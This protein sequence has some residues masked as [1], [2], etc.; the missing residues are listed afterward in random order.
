[1]LK[2]NDVSEQNVALIFRAEEQAK[3]ESSTQQAA[4]GDTLKMEALYSSET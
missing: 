3:Q 1:M 4:S 2:D